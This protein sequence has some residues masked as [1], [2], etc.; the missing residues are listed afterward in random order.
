MGVAALR[1]K[2]DFHKKTGPTSSPYSTSRSV[3]LKLRT[4]FSLAAQI[5][6]HRFAVINK[7]P[8]PKAFRRRDLRVI[9]RMID[10]YTL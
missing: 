2:S 8:Y 10:S 7:F 1:I 3:D 5:A 9:L 6:L 4:L